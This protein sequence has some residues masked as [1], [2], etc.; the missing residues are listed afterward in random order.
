MSDRYTKE[1]CTNRVNLANRVRVGVV[2]AFQLPPCPIEVTRPGKTPEQSLLL[3]VVKHDFLPRFKKSC[4]LTTLDSTWKLTHQ[5]GHIA[6][7]T[8]IGLLLQY[9]IKCDLS[10][11]CAVSFQGREIVLLVKSF[12]LGFLMFHQNCFHQEWFITDLTIKKKAQTL[13]FK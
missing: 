2:Q 9:N 10:G 8:A 11:N 4:F 7:V 5:P 6:A 13:C 3:A 1:S 12:I